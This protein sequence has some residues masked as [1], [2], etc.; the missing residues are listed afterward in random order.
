MDVAESIFSDRFTTGSRIYV[1][2]AHAQTLLSCLKHGIGQTPSLLERYLVLKKNL[3]KK[4]TR[5]L[6]Y[7]SLNAIQTELRNFDI[8]SVACMCYTS[9]RRMRLIGA[10]HFINISL[11]RSR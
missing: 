5:F 8:G 4:F 2:T 1:L 3:N 10:Q 11:Y 6:V 9:M 7:F